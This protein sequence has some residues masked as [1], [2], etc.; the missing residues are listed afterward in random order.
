MHEK[1][2]ENYPFL[3]ANLTISNIKHQLR[4]RFADLDASATK[5]TLFQNP[6]NCEVAIVP[7]QFQM[8]IIDF[9]KMIVL[10]N[11]NL[12]DFYKYA[13]K[14]ISIFGTTYFC[15]QIF[16]QMKYIKSKYR[17]GLSD[18]HLKFLLVIDISD[19]EPQFN[20]ILK[21]HEEFHHPH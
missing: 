9:K 16:S 13:R 7:S 8:E 20:Q 10:K 15:E 19:F 12:I 14:F 4:T 17:A 3:F 1:G 6:F 2:A 18:K 5:I 11:E 21:I